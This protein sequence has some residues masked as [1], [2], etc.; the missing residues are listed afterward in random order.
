MG[1]LDFHYQEGC[2]HYILCWPQKIKFF[3]SLRCL[4]ITWN[5]WHLE[6]LG[7]A[8]W[9]CTMDL[10]RG[11]WQ[12]KMREEDKPKTA[13]VT[14]KGLLRFKVMPFGLSNAPATFQRLMEKVLMGLQWQ[15]CL[16]Y[17]DDIIMFGRDFDETLA[18]LECVME[19]LKQAG[20]K[21]KPSKCRWLQKSIKYLGHIV[22]KERHWMRPREG[23]GCPTLASASDCE[24]GQAVHRVCGIL[25]QVYSK[26]FRHCQAID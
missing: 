5:W 19:R 3:D 24:G 14:R 22:S 11:Y 10:A 7:G 12:I 4:S 1:C 25:P 21:L 2:V 6:H 9:F 8:D 15:K 20:L 16:V 13:F 23:G 17:L 26:L 18:N